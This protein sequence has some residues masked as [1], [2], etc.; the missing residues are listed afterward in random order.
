[1]AAPID[2]SRRA[3]LRGDISNRN[4]V[5]HLPW[6]AANFEDLCQRCDQCIAACEERVLVRGDGGFPSVAFQRGGCTFCQACARACS[7]GAINDSSEPAW[8]IKAAVGPACLEAKG[9]TCRA[10]GETCE[11]RAIRFLLRVGGGAE[12]HLSEENCTGC[13]GC[14]SVCPV[15]AVSMQAPVEPRTL[16]TPIPV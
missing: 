14:V 12:L 7:Y 4:G 16:S 11:A 5:R 10:C 9:I 3:F 6:A 15:N 2:P 13:G 8:T 1:M